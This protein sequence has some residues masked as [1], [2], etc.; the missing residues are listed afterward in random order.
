MQ[1]IYFFVLTQ[2]GNRNGRLR[3]KNQERKDTQH[4][5]FY[6]LDWALVVL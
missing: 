1:R 6:R 4:F 5:S 2:K 3:K